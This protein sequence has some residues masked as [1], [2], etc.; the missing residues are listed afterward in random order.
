MKKWIFPIGFAL[1]IV[2]L[3]SCEKKPVIEKEKHVT[4]HYKGTLDDGTVFD[5]SEGKE[6]LSFIYGVG[7]LIPGLEAQMQGMKAGDKKTVKVAAADAYGPYH[8]EMVIPVP[9]KD[10]PKEI[11][12]EIGMQLMAQTMFGPVPVR[13]KDMDENN[14][15]IDYNSP[16]AGKDLT[17]DIQIVEVRNATEEELAPFKKAAEQTPL[18]GGALPPIPG[19]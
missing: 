4:F 17:F 16:L 5:S 14:I 15:F 8:E 13:I 18:P 10:F 12:P 7:Q 2:A 6:P 3:A 9:R 1:L 19:K 11:K